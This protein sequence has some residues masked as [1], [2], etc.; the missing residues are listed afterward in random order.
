[1]KKTKTKKKR[2]ERIA[3]ILLSVLIVFEVLILFLFIFSV[4]VPNLDY[5]IAVV[6]QNN[7]TVSTLL[8]IG[9]VYPEIV[10]ITI[11]G[12]ATSLN[13]I[14]NGTANLTVYIIALDYNGEGDIRNMSLTF[15][16]TVA[17]TYGGA[18][19][20][21]NHYTNS[22]C[23]IDRSYGNTYEANATC[24]IGVQYYAN[25]QS[26]NATV[27]VSDNSSFSDYDS[28][29]MTI[30]TLLALGLP[31]SI[32]YGLVNATAVSN[33]STANVTNFGN[34]LFNLSLSGYGKYIGDNNSMNCTLGT[35]QNI[36]IYYEKFNLT[37]T[38]TSTMTLSQFESK[39]EN[40]SSSVVTKLFHVFPRQNDTSPYFDDTN[41]TYWRIYVPLGVAGNCTGNI[42]FGAI[43]SAG[44]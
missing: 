35:V 31:N 14:P 44:T 15:F 9:N 10:N 11:N 40:L 16:D 28:G 13:L 22:S 33:E 18:N 38:N 3:G 5:A 17:S 25:N 6:G 12:G 1:M 4:I 23:I 30:N 19:D 7:V 34:T 27:I 32:D 29:L 37:V 21:N 36:S 20:N 41:A 43:K 26:W 39:Y 2:S 42:V 24:N 8:Q